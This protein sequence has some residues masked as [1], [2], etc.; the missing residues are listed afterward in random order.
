ML[1]VSEQQLPGRGRGLIAEQD[2]AAGRLLLVSPA[3]AVSSAANKHACAFCFSNVG[4]AE[5]LPCRGGCGLVWC[6][7]V[8]RQGHKRGCSAEQAPLLVAAPHSD[9]MCRMLALCGHDRDSRLVLE[10]LGRSPKNAQLAKLHAGIIK[11]A[12]EVLYA[13]SAE[14]VPESLRE[15]RDIDPAALCLPE[16]IDE[17][18]QLKSH[19]NK[20]DT[21]Y[22][23]CNIAIVAPCTPRIF[24]TVQSFLLQQSH[25]FA[26]R[27]FQVG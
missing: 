9:L 12:A 13:S 4:K 27:V 3:L 5:G 14:A 25:A 8:C 22:P 10:V 20:L 21:E 18:L 26:I 24:A 6:S 1:G 11:K 15:L 2:L 19:H 7:E 23:Q 17:M 16:S